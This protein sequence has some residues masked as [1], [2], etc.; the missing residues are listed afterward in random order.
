MIQE[1]LI[2]FVDPNKVAAKGTVAVHPVLRVYN[3][4]DPE[5]YSPPDEF[6]SQYKNKYKDLK[7]LYVD[8]NEIN[9]GDWNWLLDELRQP[10]IKKCAYEIPARF[11]VQLN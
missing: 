3:P 11:D 6:L 10:S 4:D 8:K 9:E 2:C 7:F 5:Q 1:F